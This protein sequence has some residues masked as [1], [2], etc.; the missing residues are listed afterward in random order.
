MQDAKGVE[1]N[2]FARYALKKLQEESTPERDKFVD[3]SYKSAEYHNSLIK[4]KAGLDEDV[5][6]MS[7]ICYAIKHVVQLHSLNGL[8]KCYVKSGV[9]RLAVG[10]YQ[11]P[12]AKFHFNQDYN[13]YRPAYGS[14]HLN[15]I[16]GG[17]HHKHFKKEVIKKWTEVKDMLLQPVFRKGNALMKPILEID[18]GDHVY[19]IH[20]EEREQ[21]KIGVSKQLITRFRSIHTTMG[22]E[23]LQVIKVIDLGGYELEAALHQ[24]FGKHRVWSRK[25]WFAD[26]PE[27]RS[28][29]DKLDAG[30]DPWDLI[31]SGS[32]GGIKNEQ[33]VA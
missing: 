28:F 14:Y 10:E 31:N 7:A 30:E 18:Y 22:R 17:Y 27:I 11:L 29:I 23:K 25:E 21:I 33:E 16:M 20:D 13:C 26:H 6:K 3:A 2:K 19:F 24:F 15:A 8:S 9:D 5:R 1:M 4:Q 12:I 32:E